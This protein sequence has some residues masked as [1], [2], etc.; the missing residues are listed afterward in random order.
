[1]TFRTFAT[2][3]I[4][5]LFAL[6]PVTGFAH[7]NGGFDDFSYDDL[8]EDVGVYSDTY[9][10]HYDS[11]YDD[12]YGNSYYG[13]QRY[14]SSSRTTYHP[15]NTMPGFR[16]YYWGRDG[17]CMNYSYRQSPSYYGGYPYGYDYGYNDYGYE[18]YGYGNR[19]G[20]RNCY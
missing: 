17:T 13:N 15:Q 5:A 10:V 2:G 16:C 1:M 20:H 7:H 4:S 6:L 8:Y 3:F 18:N 19:C 14:N 9:S 11:T 12:P